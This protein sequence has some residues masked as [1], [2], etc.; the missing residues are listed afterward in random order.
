[1]GKKLIWFFVLIL[2]LAAA[3]CGDEEEPKAPTESEP[4]LIKGLS[5]D[6]YM[7]TKYGVKI[8]NLPVDLWTVKAL[9]A[10]GQG[11]RVQG[12]SAYS[13]YR[14][15]LME[16]VSS[17]EFVGFDESGNIEPMLDADIPFIYISL[18]HTEGAEFSTHALSQ[19][20]ESYADWHSAEI[21]SKK[22]V[23]VGDAT[24]IQAVLLRSDGL[25]EALT[26]FAKG[27][28]L[29]RCEYWARDPKYST[30]LPVYE[31][32]VENICLMGS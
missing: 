19:D 12:T 29:V 28:V 27:E 6:T 17:D 26:W 1:M 18:E 8:T 14:L 7:N 11:F 24:G 32:V 9:G 3:G 16:P 31:L 13:F 5:G 10:D 15:L 4:K 25:K 23:A 22:F 20:L 21:E 30:Y 2:I